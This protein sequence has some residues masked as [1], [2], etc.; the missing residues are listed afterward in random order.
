MRYT[1][2]DDQQVILLTAQA[3]HIVAYVQR[4]QPLACD[5]ETHFIFTVG[6]FIQE[7]CAQLVFLWMVVGH[8]DHFNS[9]VAQSID[10]RLVRGD[11]LRRTGALFDWAGLPAFEPHTVLGQG[12]LDVVGM[13][14]HF[15]RGVRGGDG[16]DGYI[17]HCTVPWFGSCNR[18]PMIMAAARAARLA[19][20]NVKVG[21]SRFQL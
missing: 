15:V 18:R 14:Q 4:K 20:L 11:H 17:A 8:A 1:G 2:R 6:T 13:G 7:L 3:V 21:P 5:E 16:V 9:G 19:I 10:L 12:R